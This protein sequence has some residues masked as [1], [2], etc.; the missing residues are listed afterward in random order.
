MVAPSCAFAWL[1]V[2]LRA[3]LSDGPDARDDP[4]PDDP[5]RAVKAAALPGPHG[6]HVPSRLSETAVCPG[7]EPTSGEN[8]AD[9][10]TRLGGDGERVG[11]GD[12]GVPTPC[13]L[14]DEDSPR[15]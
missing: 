15:A 12:T 4:S 7:D 2:F 8:P 10:P 9:A 6:G 3:E 13:L 11:P 5:T 1:G 14:A